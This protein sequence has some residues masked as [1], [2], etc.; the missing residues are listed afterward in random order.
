MDLNKKEKKYLKENVRKKP[1]TQ[2]AQ[3]LGVKKESLEE[4]L[5]RIWRSDKF[6]TFMASQKKSSQALLAKISQ[7]NLKTF[8]R[9]NL[10]LI[11]LLAFLII[12]VYGNGLNNEFLSD[13]IAAISKNKDLDKPAYILQSFPTF[14]RPSIYFLTNLAF[15]RNPIAFRISNLLFHFLAT[16]GLL[17]LVSLLLN[18]TVGII[19]AFIFA[20]HPLLVESVTWI[21]GGS[22]SQY[23]A[24]LIWATIFYLLSFKNKRYYWLCLFAFLLALTSSEKAMVFP[25]LLLALVITHWQD[26]GKDK[27]WQKLVIPFLI[28]FVWIGFYLTKVPERLSDLETSY[29]QDT[30]QTPSFFVKLPVA[31]GSYLGLF[32]WPQKLTLYHSETMFS[33][34]QFAFLLIIFLLFI[35]AVIGLFF[36]KKKRLS[37]WPAWFLLSLGPVLSPFGVSWVVAERYAYLGVAGLVVLVAFLIEKFF[38]RENLKPLGVG[39]VTILVISLG[40]R[41]IIRNIDWK[42]QDNLWLAAAKT[43]P[44]SPQNHNNLGDLWARRGDFDQAIEEFK[45]AI[46]LNPRYA[47]AYHNLANIYQQKG[48][49]E[50]ALENYQRAIEINPNIWQTYQNMAAIYFEIGQLEKAKESAL[51]LLE[52]NPQVPHIYRNLGLIYYNLGQAEEAKKYLQ[53]ALQI[54]PQDEEIKNILLKL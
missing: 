16:G 47:D 39:L 46:T 49:W 11:I 34:W 48:D 29:Y 45:I 54:S 38:R 53:A 8:T 50:K 17:V 1:L 24:L 41:T 27:S 19:S 42:N 18:K 22:Y 52:I 9:N 20:V 37:F 3:D 43:S 31:I 40:I 6:K 4:Y 35:M 5:S 51:K 44:N 10:G 32:I 26:L 36:S 14:F 12:A 7:F 25:F 13:D 21:S 28:G 23:A 33:G 15:G 2:I 30:S